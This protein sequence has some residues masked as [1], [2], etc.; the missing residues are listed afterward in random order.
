MYFD[1]QKF[2]SFFKKDFVEQWEIQ[3]PD[4]KIEIRISQSKAPLE[5]MQFAPCKQITGR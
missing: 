3:N 5:I 1:E 4:F 2:K